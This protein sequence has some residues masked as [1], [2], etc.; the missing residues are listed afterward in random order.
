MMRDELEGRVRRLERVN[1]VLVAALVVLGG[2]LGWRRVTAEVVRADR[3]E[4]VDAQGR[5]RIVLAAGEAG[6]TVE[7][8]DAAGVAR[9]TLGDD[10]EG[11]ALYLR[12]G[13]GTT[14]VGVAQFAHGGGGFALHGP[15]AKGAAVLYLKGDGS[16]TF[17][18]ANGEVQA[19]Y[20]GG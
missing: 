9:A 16:L 6:P 15:E 20:P 1:G 18:G 2:A 19:R 7:V 17:Y 8:R 4:V 11:T 14:R 5:A 13:D 10:A 3:I 12:D